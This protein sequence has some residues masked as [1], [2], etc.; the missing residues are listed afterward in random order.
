LTTTYFGADGKVFNVQGGAESRTL[1]L[2]QIPTG[3]NSSGNNTINVTSSGNPYFRSNGVVVTFN[4][5]PGGG[6]DGVQ[7]GTGS[8]AAV[9]SSSGSNSIAVTSNNTSGS[10]HA[11]AS[12]ALIAECLIRVTP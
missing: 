8:L 11:T 12:P 4:T 10:A 2:A 5:S 6:A 3:I 7:P 1:T 9:S